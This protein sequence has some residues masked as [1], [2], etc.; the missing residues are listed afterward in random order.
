MNWK[1]CGRKQSL[2]HLRYYLSICL[3]GLR[4][5]T[6]YL[7]QDSRSPGQDMNLGRPEYE[8]GVLTTR[9]RHLV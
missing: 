6:K 3:E 9:P 7:S 4:N 8:A 1:E 5:I 2:P